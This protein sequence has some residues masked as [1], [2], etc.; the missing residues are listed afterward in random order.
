METPPASPMKY[1]AAL[2]V[3]QHHQQQLLKEE[4]TYANARP[5]LYQSTGAAGST[6]NRTHPC[7]LESMESTVLD[8]MMLEAKLQKL[9]MSS[10]LNLAAPLSPISEKPS[11]LDLPQDMLSRSSSTSNTRSVSA[12][13]SNESVAGDSGVFEASRAHL[14][15]KELAQV[16][17]GLKYLKPQEVLVVSLERANN[18]T[19]LW[20]ASTDNSQV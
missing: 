13:V 4:P 11:L 1:N 3:A 19:A 17:I 18:L 8:C 7:D 10:P 15:K 5:P 12:A 16:Q 9:N 14:P 20:T 2:D 6:A